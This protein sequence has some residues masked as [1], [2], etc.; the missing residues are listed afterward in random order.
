MK[1]TALE[2]FS[3]ARWRK[4]L[5]G[6]ILPR[7]APARRCVGPAARRGP[8]QPSVRKRQP[9]ASAVASPPNI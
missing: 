9:V 6:A 5:R 3:A 8:R 2:S 7:P 1:S 4:K